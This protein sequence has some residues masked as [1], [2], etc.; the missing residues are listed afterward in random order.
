MRQNE[1]EG[2]QQNDLAQAGQQQADLSLPQRHKALLAGDL[3]AHGKNARHVN[4][5]GPRGVLDQC[6]VRGENARHRAGKQHHQQP[7]Q[8]GVGPAQRQLKT[9]GFLDAG[10]LACAEVEAHH[11]LSALTDALNGQRA[12]LGCA[13]DDG[14]GT[15]SHIAAVPRQTGAEADGKQAFGGEHHK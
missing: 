11:R 9:E 8:A 7:E 1:D 13:G 6:G 2:N 4:A 3:E 10:L 12:Q 5:H 15:H 14:H